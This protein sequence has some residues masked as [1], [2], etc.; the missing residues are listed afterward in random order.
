MIIIIS[1]TH[2]SWWSSGQKYDLFL[3]PDEISCIKCFCCLFEVS[4]DDD[5]EI[6]IVVV[7]FFLLSSHQEN[8]QF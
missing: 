4:A 2:L 7:K 6:L 3:F 1:D 5:D 8:T